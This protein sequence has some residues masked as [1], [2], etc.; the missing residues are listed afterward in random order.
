MHHDGP[1]LKSTLVL[2]GPGYSPDCRE[3]YYLIAHIHPVPGYLCREIRRSHGASSTRGLRRHL[4]D[5]PSISSQDVNS[6]SSGVKL[7]SSFGPLSVHFEIKGKPRQCT[8]TG[9]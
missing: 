1:I 6:A 4:P 7:A 9:H 3:S 8:L 5:D 2:V